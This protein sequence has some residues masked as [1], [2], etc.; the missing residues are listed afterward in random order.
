MKVGDKVKI[1]EDVASIRHRKNKNGVISRI[2]GAYIYVI[3]MWT[4]FEIELYEQEIC[5]FEVY[6]NEIKK[7]KK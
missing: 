1:L 6:E 4:K 3:P 2:N 5:T 7:V